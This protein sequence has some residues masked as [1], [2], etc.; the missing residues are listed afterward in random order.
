MGCKYKKQQQSKTTNE[1]IACLYDTGIT[2]NFSIIYI[3]ITTVT[4]KLEN[5]SRATPPPTIKYFINV[6][7]MTPQF[8]PQS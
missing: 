5:L 7:L 4:I 3:A 6:K 1:K 2:P 8:G